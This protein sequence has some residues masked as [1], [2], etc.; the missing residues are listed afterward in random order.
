MEEEVRKRI[1]HVLDE[2]NV[3]VNTL[4]IKYKENQSKLSKQ[5]K[6]KTAISLNTILLLLDEFPDLST[7]WLLR[8]KGNMFFTTDA[9]HSDLESR[10]ARLEQL[11][12]NK[13]I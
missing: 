4:A 1:R 3:K 12:N 6:Y 5:I 11:I 2:K 10:V 13:T 8:G 7:E 9:N